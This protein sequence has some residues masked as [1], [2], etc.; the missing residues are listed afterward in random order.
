MYT[1]AKVPGNPREILVTIA[2]NKA[3]RPSGDHVTACEN[4]IILN[5][6]ISLRQGLEITFF[7]SFAI[8]FYSRLFLP[9]LNTALLLRHVRF[10][11]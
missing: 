11:G 1:L 8:Y 9:F 10:S 2:V 3:Q 5:L 4:A 7:F 6:W